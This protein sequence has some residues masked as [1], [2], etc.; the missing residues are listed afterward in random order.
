MKLSSIFLSVGLALFSLLPNAKAQYVVSP[1]NIDWPSFLQRHDL[2]WNRIE[3]DYYA[4]AIMGNG[5]LGNNIYKE[6]EAYKFHIGRVDVTEGRMPNP[7]TD[8]RNLYHGA[9]LPIG[10]FLLKPVG[11]VRSEQ[12]RLNLWN[13]VTTG[14]LDTDSGKIYFKSYVH[15]TKDVIVVETNSLGDEEHWSWEWKPLKAVSPRFLIGR[16]DYPQEYADHPNPEVKVHQ[17]GN[18][19]LSVQNLYGGK[20]YVVAWCETKNGVERRILITISQENTEADAVAKAKETLAEAMDEDKEAF[21]NA[22][23]EWWHKYYPVSFVSFP[24]AK[25]ESFYWIQQYKFAC[26]TRPDKYIIDLQG[27]WAVDKTPWPAVWMNLNAQLTYSPVF[28]ANRAELS[29]PLWKAMDDY[30]QNLIDNV[31]QQ[32]RDDAAVMGRST[33]Y[34][35]YSP[36]HPEDDNKM[37]YETGNLT[38]LLFYYYQYCT[39]TGNAEELTGKFYPLLKRSIAYYE[40]IREKRTDGKYHLPETSSPEY[41]TAKDC[42]YDLSL[43]RWGL[44]TLL[45]INEQYRLNDVKES[46][47][48][49]FLA[50]LTDYPIDPEKGYMIGE[51][52]NM[53]YSHRHYSHL[54]MI[55]PLYMVNWEQSENRGLISKSLSHWQSMTDYLQGYSFT[56]SSS[57]YSMAGDGERAVAQLQKLLGRYIQP[58]TLYKESGPVIETPFA[59]AASLQDLYLQSWGGKIRVFPAIP[60]QWRQ[61]SFINLRAEGAFLIS[62]FR[63]DGKTTFIQ[64]VSEI[65]GICHLQTA[66]NVDEMEAVNM[67]TG[68]N[69]NYTVKDRAQGGIE[70][71]TEAGDIVQFRVKGE[72]C[73][74]PVPLIHSCEEC[75]LYGVRK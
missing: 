61:A 40:H 2:L 8:Y 12:M 17:E 72:N 43:L 55:F 19:H 33:S 65:G 75:N 11:T 47:W 20:T 23:Q 9:R 62:A 52:V 25:M 74:Y 70:I 54:L 13:A 68:E 26:I 64:V 44:N 30:R 71:R 6:G 3:P 10:H 60:S 67:R 38:W 66:M 7:K 48:Q 59:G 15:A 42:N 16:T 14:L 29:R 5:L 34:H 4:G 39:W 57:M 46:D 1:Q 21:E 35:L 37:L 58:N 36:L 27:P 51:G 28:T 53:T 49:D 32:W 56:G 31:P 41:G 24:D 63:N 22:H 73:F 18:V 45:A 50:N 69:V